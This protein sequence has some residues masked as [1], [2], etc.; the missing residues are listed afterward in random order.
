MKLKLTQKI[1]LLWIPGL[2]G[3]HGNEAVDN[4]LKTKKY[5]IEDLIN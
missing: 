3:I 4:L 1:T 2:I 5:A